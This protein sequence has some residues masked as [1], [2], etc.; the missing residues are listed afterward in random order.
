MS[1]DIPKT[2]IAI[3]ISEFG[4]PEVLKPVERRVP[5]VREREL[6]VRVSAAGINF[7]DTMQR[8]G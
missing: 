5:E 6:L 4:G 1:F 8:E 7:P 2:M 3:E